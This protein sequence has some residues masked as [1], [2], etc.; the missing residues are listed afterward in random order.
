MIETLL[1]LSRD[2]GQ[3]ARSVSPWSDLAFLVTSSLV[4]EE[5]SPTTIDFACPAFDELKFDRLWPNLIGTDDIKKNAAV[6]GQILAWRMDCFTP[7]G[8]SF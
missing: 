5:P 2:P 3:T 7:L 4:N 6:S 8:L 1:P